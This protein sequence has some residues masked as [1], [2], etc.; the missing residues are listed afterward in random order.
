MTEELSTEWLVNTLRRSTQEVF[1]TM[2]GLDAE[3]G[4]A[5]REGDTRSR[6]DGV[7]SL[8]GLAGNWVGAGSLSCSAETACELSS[9][10]LLTEL[11]AVDE[12]V[13]D[14]V[15]EL[16]NM[17]IGKFKTEIEQRLGPMG[18]SIPT[19]INGH[20]FHARSMSARRWLVLPFMAVDRRFE[21]R[22]CLAR[23]AWAESSR[24]ASPAEARLRTQSA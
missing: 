6:A 21:V 13:L 16:T 24:G 19:V 12:E 2:L 8:V 3:A 9:R 18:L 14:A 15:G 1:S 22:V 23:Q 20:D 7:V 11:K 10:M 17:V 4:E 5:Y